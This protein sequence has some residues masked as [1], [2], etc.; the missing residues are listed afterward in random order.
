M[1]HWSDKNSGPQLGARIQ[2]S[3]SCSSIH[4]IPDS[5]SAAAD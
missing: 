1:V 2:G 5:P 4:V 3:Q